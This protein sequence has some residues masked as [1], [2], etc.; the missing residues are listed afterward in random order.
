MDQ[1][2]TAYS[3]YHHHHTYDCGGGQISKVLYLKMKEELVFL[4]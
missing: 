2:S 3:A 1:L 4:F